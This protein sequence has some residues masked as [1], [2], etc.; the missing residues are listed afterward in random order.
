MSSLNA[1]F[2]VGGNVEPPADQYCAVETAIS[3][4]DDSLGRHWLRC[5]CRSQRQP[6][7][8]LACAKTSDCRD[9]SDGPAQVAGDHNRSCRPENSSRPCDS[10]HN[11]TL[12]RTAILSVAD[13]LDVREGRGSRYAAGAT[14]NG[15]ERCVVVRQTPALSTRSAAL[16]AEGL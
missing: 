6:T 13:P 16:P 9:R 2:Q 3:A 12:R 8:L 14:R 15:T 11:R 10:P 5:N 1:V 4:D 7:R